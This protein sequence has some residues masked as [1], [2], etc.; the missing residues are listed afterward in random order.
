[1]ALA[2]FS[3]ITYAQ[4]AVQ[5]SQDMN[6]NYVLNPAAGGTEDY[7]DIKACFRK[8]W[9]NIPGSP[10]TYYLTAHSPVFKF[11]GKPHPIRDK[12]R[13]FH[14][15]G[16][17]IYRDETGPI[18]RMGLTASYGYNMSLSRLFRISVAAAIGIQQWSLNGGML[19]SAGDTE[20]PNSQYGMVPDATLGVWA[21][22]THMYFGAAATQ[23]TRQTLPYQLPNSTSAFKKLANH[24]YITGGVRI[25]MLY[26]FTLIPSIMVKVNTPAIPSV[27]LNAK[28]K[29]QDLLWAGVSYRNLDSFIG[30]VGVTINKWIDVG[31]S[32]DAT[33]SR[34]GG[35]TTGSHEI[36]VGVRLK[37]RSQLICPSN[38]W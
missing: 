30:M 16:G 37:P 36:L 27:D 2:L 33:V 21:Y 12:Y 10:T 17:N 24:Y 3:G 22:N 26:E 13:N 29:Y 15:L 5:Y 34:L 14:A 11:R 35:H 25:P 38:F 6:N 18:S 7:V 23:L 8:Q 31:Y 20:R 1:M 9:V 4:Q 28:L 19:K 32:Y